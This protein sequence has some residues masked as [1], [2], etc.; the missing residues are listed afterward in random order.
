MDDR[1]TFPVL[2]GQKGL[3]TAAQLRAAGW[4]AAQ[5]RH[6][7][8]TAWQVPFPCVYAPHRGPLDAT[9]WLTAAALWAGRR[10]VL[11]GTAALRQHG[12]PVPPARRALFVVPQTGRAR[13]RP[14]VRV[15]RSWR[16]VAPVPGPGVVRIAPAGRA[17]ADAAAYESPGPADVEAW[18]I[19]VLQRGLATPEQLQLEL[20][21]RPQARVAAAHQGLEA[22]RGGAWSR[23]E[24]A[25][26][27]IFDGAGDLPELLTN[28]G[29]L[30][31]RDGRLIG[32][33]DGYLPSLGVVL[34][35]HSR[36]HHQGFDDRGGDRWARTVE[37]DSAYAAAGAR[38]L[39]VSPW[40]LYTRP[41]LFLARLRQTVALGPAFPMPAVRVVPAP[42]RGRPG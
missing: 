30:D 39:G 8:A 15:V 31:E 26:R 13:A 40:T 14:A 3:A 41:A 37:R 21:Q 9:T 19:A 38:V 4:T 28:V 32:C 22:F 10:A 5:V 27:T 2:A 33:P 18:T 1:P 29:L 20:W 23:P 35:V 12:L 6:A 36:Q 16:P 24:V 7:R 11:T 25:L 42:P 34:Q 17:L